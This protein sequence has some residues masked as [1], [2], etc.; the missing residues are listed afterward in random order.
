MA[1]VEGVPDRPHDPPDMTRAETLDKAHGRIET[2]RIA[3]RKPPARLNLLWPDVRQICRVERIREMKT[4]CERQIIYVITS[5][6]PEIADAK[7]LLE[8]ARDHWLIENRLHRVKD[9][10]FAEDACKVRSGNAPIA[11]ALIRNRALAIIRKGKL[12][13]KDAREAFAAKPNAA[14]KAVLSG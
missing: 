9:G 7:R 14:I 1:A 8:I 11:L 2:R 12:K 3:V 10:T 4:Y 5:L 13:P 6:P